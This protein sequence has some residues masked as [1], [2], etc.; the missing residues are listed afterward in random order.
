MLLFTVKK[1]V[2]RFIDSVRCNNVFLRIIRL[3]MIKHCMKCF[4]FIGLLSG[5]DN[6][7]QKGLTDHV[8]ET[9]QM[10]VVIPF[11]VNKAR[12]IIVLNN[13]RIGS[14]NNMTTITC[15]DAVMCGRNEMIVSQREKQMLNI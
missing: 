14:V 13:F 15:K 7:V 6:N 8:N 11:V 5:L 3:E 2:I 12:F 4:A 1:K 9:V 10:H